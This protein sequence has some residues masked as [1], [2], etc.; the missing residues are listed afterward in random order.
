[1][2]GVARGMSSNR[3]LSVRFFLLLPFSFP[4]F[5]CY[6]FSK[7][8]SGFL[9]SVPWGSLVSLN[10]RSCSLFGF[11]IL[12][13]LFLFLIHFPY[14]GSLFYLLNWVLNLGFFFKFLIW[15]PYFGSLFWFLVPYLGSLLGS[16]FAFLIL[17]PILGSLF[18]FPFGVPYSD[19][20]LV[21]YSGTLY[22]F[23]TWDSYSS[24]L[25]QFLIWV[26]CVG[27]F[28]GF[29][30]QFLILIPYLSSL[31]FRAWLDWIVFSLVFYFDLMQVSTTFLKLNTNY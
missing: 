10:Y 16:L 24:S 25:F 19:S 22:E 13:F 8:K 20:L 4:L 5:Q 26:P 6:C 30:F 18:G 11:L 7:I 15:I 1:M 2:P 27:S 21:P 23:L 3:L 28:Y 17:V 14:S 31:A 29:L 9:G 12:A